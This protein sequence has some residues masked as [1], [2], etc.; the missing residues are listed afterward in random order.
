MNFN[1]YE[2]LA[3]V[4]VS[5]ISCSRNFKLDRIGTC[6]SYG[7][8]RVVISTVQRWQWNFSS[9][10]QERYTLHH[11]SITI[12]TYLNQS[13]KTSG[14][15]KIYLHDGILDVNLIFFVLIFIKRGPRQQCGLARCPRKRKHH[16]P[17][18]FGLHLG[19]QSSTAGEVPFIFV[20]ERSRRRSP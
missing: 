12:L 5:S 10:Q 19:D 6:C 7:T 3:L 18:R 17:F 15:S 9:L 20:C 16:S 4:T 11:F 8:W 1:K 2:G 14:I 13:W